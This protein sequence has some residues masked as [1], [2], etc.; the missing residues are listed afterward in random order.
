MKRCHQE[1]DLSSNR[2]ELFGVDALAA[3][4]TGA[5]RNGAGRSGVFQVE[6]NLGMRN[7]THKIAQ[8][9]ICM[10]CLGIYPDMGLYAIRSY[11]SNCCFS[12]LY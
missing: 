10:G 7:E 4:L 3:V 8:Y 1:L 11:R 12:F 2:V 5:V 6:V 9:R